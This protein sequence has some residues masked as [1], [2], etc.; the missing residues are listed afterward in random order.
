MMHRGRTLR[1]AQHSGPFAHDAKTDIE[2]TNSDREMY[3]VFKMVANV[4]V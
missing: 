1:R 3:V 2:V 4:A